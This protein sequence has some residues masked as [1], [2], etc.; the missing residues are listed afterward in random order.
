[1]GLDEILKR[2]KDVRIQGARNIAIAGLKAYKLKP[3]KSTIKK[4]LSLRETEPALENALKFAEKNSIKE[5]LEH[6]KFSKEEIKRIGW[7]VVK[8]R[9]FT[10]CHSSHVVDV[11]IEAKKRGKK[12]EV[13]NTETRPLYQ[14]RKTARDLAKAGIKVTMIADLEAGDVLTD[15]GE[16]NKVDVMLIGADAV[17]RNGDVINKVGSGMLAELAYRH[18]IPVYVV[19]GSWKFSHKNV[20][21][22]ERSFKELWKNAPKH[23]KIKNPAFEVIKAKYI[24]GIVS[25]LGILSVKDFLKKVKKTYPWI[26]KT[27]DI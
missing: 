9:V 1:M 3:T 12:F 10:H 7:N 17:L 22:E 21:I 25:E 26:S 2:I 27:K 15:R 14:G 18:N 8:K 4:L 16:I 20:D 6:F 5:S 24:K 11:L 13:Y 19:T 23:V